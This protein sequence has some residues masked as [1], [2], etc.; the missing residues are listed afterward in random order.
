MSMRIGTL[1][2][3]ETLCRL[4]LSVP[5]PAGLPCSSGRPARHEKGPALGWWPKMS[6][7]IGALSQNTVR[8]SSSRPVCGAFWGA[9]KNVPQKTSR[10]WGGGQKSRYGSG[11]FW[12]LKSS[13]SLGKSCFLRRHQQ[14]AVRKNAPR[15]TFRPSGGGQN[16]R[17]GSG[18][19]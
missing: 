16:R 1:L 6:I 18:P 4:I 10:P 7:Q 12:T 11:P 17:Y 13:H 5:R 9:H 15:K 8:C 2:D 19:F 3:P 14:T